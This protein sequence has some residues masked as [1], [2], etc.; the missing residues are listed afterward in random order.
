LHVV[1]T[2]KRP[3]V[4]NILRRDS[5]LTRAVEG[6]ME[7]CTT[8]RKQFIVLIDLITEGNRKT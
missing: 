5:L 2:R 4:R 1:L 3:W 7:G 6:R 8:K